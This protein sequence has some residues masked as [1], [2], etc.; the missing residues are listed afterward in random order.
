MPSLLAAILS[1]KELV[2]STDKFCHFL[3]V[4]LNCLCAIDFKRFQ[5]CSC[6]HAMMSHRF[7]C[8]SDIRMTQAR[9]WDYQLQT[10]QWNF[11]FK[12]QNP[13]SNDPA[14]AGF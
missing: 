3:S 9:A 10:K 4:C 8:Q 11:I 12:T 7:S 14:L 1:P 13:F 5:I 2:P 6:S